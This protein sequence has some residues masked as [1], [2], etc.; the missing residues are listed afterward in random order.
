M[1]AACR[2]RR[3]FGNFNA[4]NCGELAH[5]EPMFETGWGRRRACCSAGSRYWR[6]M[7]ID[8]FRRMMLPSGA[9]WPIW[10]EG[11]HTDELDC[12]GVARERGP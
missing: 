4:G 12:V 11:S 2:L 9:R 6:V 7:I 1:T 10:A 3:L 5:D 8:I